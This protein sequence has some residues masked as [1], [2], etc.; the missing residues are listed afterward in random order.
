MISIILK[1]RSMDHALRLKFKIIEINRVKTW[2]LKICL[3]TLF[4]KWFA[5]LEKS[6]IRYL[7]PFEK[8]RGAVH[9]SISQAIREVKGNSSPFDNS[10]HSISPSFDIL[11]YSISQ[12]GW[13]SIRYLKEESSI[14]HLKKAH[15]RSHSRTLRSLAVVERV[16]EPKHY[17]SSRME[18][19]RQI[20]EEDKIR[21]ADQTR[22]PS[23][24]TCLLCHTGKP[25]RKLGE[26]VKQTNI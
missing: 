11:S 23:R 19:W 18:F 15:S 2:R 22:R 1:R 14:R 21:K 7:K 25:T 9:H 8:S 13:R 3:S 6:R 16:L 12:T 26:R 10:S 4:E 5:P 17:S 20:T 24:I